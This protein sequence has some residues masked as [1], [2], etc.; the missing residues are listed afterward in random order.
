MVF[1]RI[2]PCEKHISCADNSL[3]ESITMNASNKSQYRVA[4]TA[5]ILTTALAI[6]G[7]IV[8]TLQPTGVTT[9]LGLGV[10]WGI[11]FAFFIDR[12]RYRSNLSMTE[13][14]LFAGLLFAPMLA[15]L[16][17]LPAQNKIEALVLF[18]SVGVVPASVV[19]LYRTFTDAT[20]V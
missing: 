5:T 17:V 14:A 4:I 11:V 7:Y 1:V 9:S 18:Y 16:V 3:N 12:D 8:S 19:E 20:P 13:Y 15:I 2:S 10:V 6:V